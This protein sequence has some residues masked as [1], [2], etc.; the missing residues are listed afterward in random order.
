MANEHR[1]EATPENYKVWAL[2]RRKKN[3]D[4]RLSELDESGDVQW[5]AP[6]THCPYCGVE[7]DKEGIAD[8]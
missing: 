6:I 3:R 7:L 8:G 5:T 2:Y 1:C 4:W